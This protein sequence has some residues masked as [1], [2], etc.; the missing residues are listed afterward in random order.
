MSYINPVWYNGDEHAR[1]LK[2]AD[3]VENY[4]FTI[5]LQIRT[6]CINAGVK[7]SEIPVGLDGFLTSDVLV[8]FGIATA[9]YEVF[10]GHWGIRATGG[11]RDIYDLKREQ[12]QVKINEAKRMLNRTNILGT[13]DEKI[14]PVNTARLISIPLV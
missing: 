14:D 6:N 12:Y 8:Q 3:H 10:T 7:V 13:D 4:N 2:V 1:A 9:I 5:D 11:D